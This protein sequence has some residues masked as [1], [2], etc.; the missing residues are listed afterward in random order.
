MPRSGV[1]RR[2]GRPR[3]RRV[4][5]GH[6]RVAH[7][8][9]AAVAG[10]RPRRQPRRHAVA[11]GDA[12]RP[13]GGAGPRRGR[14]PPTPAQLASISRELS[15]NDPDA[16]NGEDGHPDARGARRG[17][18]RR[19]RGA[20]PALARRP[21][22]ARAARGSPRT[23]PRAPPT[24]AARWSAARPPGSRPPPPRQRRRAPSAAS[25]SACTVS[26][27]ATTW[28]ISASRSS[29]WR[30]SRRIAS[31]CASRAAFTAGFC[32][33]AIR[34][35]IRCGGRSA[36][37]AWIRSARAAW[38]SMAADQRV[39]LA[40]DVVEREPRRLDGAHGSTSR[41]R[42]SPPAGARRSPG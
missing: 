30:S 36:R 25:T 11:L 41:A 16:S 19:A 15:F 40:D 38:P 10:A 27:V 24:R 3:R 28:S 35:S 26:S 23:P 6:D 7:R 21:I 4:L 34:R 22:M 12:A 29:C 8:L 2:P 39:H 17:P 5:A 1:T 13:R 33:S 31:S 20:R 18:Q 14:E 37:N 42:R 9:A 32:S